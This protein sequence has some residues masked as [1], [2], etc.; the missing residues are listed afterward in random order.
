MSMLVVLLALLLLVTCEANAVATPSP[1]ATA[2]MDVTATA[3]A[4][5]PPAAKATAALGT[6]NN[7]VYPGDFPDPDVIVVDGTYYAYATN[8]DGR[9]IQVAHSADLVTWELLGDALPQ[10]PGWAV[11][12]FGWAWA[13]DVMAVEQG[14]LLYFTARLAMGSGGI[15]CIGVATGKAPE[16]RFAPVGDAP[17]VCQQDEG[18]SIDPATFGAGD[19]SRYLLWKN[20]GNSRGG[21]TWIYIQPLAPDGLS[22][23]GEPVRL[24]GADQAWEGGLIEG[25]TLWEHAGRTYLFYSANAYDSQ[26]YAVGYAVAE[27]ILGPYEKARGPLLETTLPAAVVGPGG[28]DVVMAGDGST[29]LLFHSW[30]P[31]E[32]RHLNLAPLLWQEGVP[33]VPLS[34]EPQPA[35]EARNQ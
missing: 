35:P 23:T 5:G 6:Y 25:P 29:W 16:G 27:E 2:A 14:Y 12:E 20:D 19:G 18:G 7:P 11:Q 10:L 26:R 30:S 9:N 28:Q 17:L 15:Q 34:R 24:L 31:R 4:A 1:Q 8:S 22:L 33:A 21:Q 3:T 13:P 32:G